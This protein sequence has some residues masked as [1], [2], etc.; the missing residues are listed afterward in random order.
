MGIGLAHRVRERDGRRDIVVYPGND[1][2]GRDQA[3]RRIFGGHSGSN[4][5]CIAPAL[6][7]AREPRRGAP[8][9]PGRP[10]A[11]EPPNT[12]RSSVCSWR[13]LLLVLKPTY[14]GS[15]WRATAAAVA[16][17]ADVRLQSGRRDSVNRNAHPNPQSRKGG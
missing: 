6:P 12:A 11:R 1:A 2:D 17:I 3:K 7:P 5:I 13:Y 8:P 4:T 10:G 14:N 9:V 15:F 16:Q